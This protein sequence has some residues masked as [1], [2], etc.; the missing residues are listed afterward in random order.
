MLI[1]FKNQI[2]FL[3]AN[4]CSLPDGVLTPS[5]VRFYPFGENCNLGDTLLLRNMLFISTIFTLGFYVKYMTKKEKKVRMRSYGCGGISGGT[6]GGVAAGVDRF[7]G[8]EKNATICRMN[9]M[10][11]M[12]NPTRTMAVTAPMR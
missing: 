7:S 12:M 9:A 5:P 2:L 1:W 3:L 4:S 11:I 10:K 6:G 8:I